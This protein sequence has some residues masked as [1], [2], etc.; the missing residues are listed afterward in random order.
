MSQGPQRCHRAW[1]CDLVSPVP[2]VPIC[3]SDVAAVCL[4]I[5]QISSGHTI[6]NMSPGEWGPLA[7]A[8]GLWAAVANL[9][10]APGAG[11]RVR[12]WVCLS[13]SLGVPAASSLW[14]DS[15]GKETVF[16]VFLCLFLCPSGPSWVLPSVGTHHIHWPRVPTGC[17]LPAS[18]CLGDSEWVGRWWSCRMGLRSS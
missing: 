5:S 18:S 13:K 1:N 3:C 11:P 2:S 17:W 8:W 10:G 15:P 9:R 12:S 16:G 14:G 4:G 7:G 6:A